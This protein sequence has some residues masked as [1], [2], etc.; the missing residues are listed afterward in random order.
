LD[1]KTVFVNF[2]AMNTGYRRKNFSHFWAHFR[3]EA[4]ETRLSAPIP[5]PLARAGAAK[6]TPLFTDS[7]IC[8]RYAVLHWFIHT[9]ARADIGRGLR[10]FRF[11]PRPITH[12]NQ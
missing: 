1:K 12:A 3:R 6:A 5:P 10:Y 8:W 2:P 7:S 4:P 11:N 9:L